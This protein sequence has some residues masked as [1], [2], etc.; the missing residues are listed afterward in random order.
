MIEM[1]KHIRKSLSTMLS[2]LRL[3]SISLYQ[4]SRSREQR[5]LL[6]SIYSESQHL[7]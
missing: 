1:R 3:F 4:C 6:R 7:R 5:I 2:V